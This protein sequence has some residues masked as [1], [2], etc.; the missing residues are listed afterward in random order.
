V[1]VEPTFLELSCFVCGNTM[2]CKLGELVTLVSPVNPVKKSGYFV[3]L[4]QFHLVVCFSGNEVETFFEGG[5]GSW[6]ELCEESGVGM[7]EVASELVNF[8][9]ALSDSYGEELFLCTDEDAVGSV[10][11]D[12]CVEAKRRRS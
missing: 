10:P 6:G 5:Y 11:G 9:V 12:A 7:V 2:G 8:C 1:V 4:S 3:P